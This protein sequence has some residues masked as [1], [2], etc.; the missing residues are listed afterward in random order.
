M[1]F[2]NLLSCKADSFK[3]PATYFACRR[4]C[5]KEKTELFDDPSIFTSLPCLT[6]VVHSS[7]HCTKILQCRP[8]FTLLA[9]V[10]SS[11]LQVTLPVP[12][13]VV[14]SS[15]YLPVHCR[16]FFN[17]LYQ[18]CAVSSNLHVTIPRPCNV[19]QL[20]R[21]RNMPAKYRPLHQYVSV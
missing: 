1:K 17:L 4:C 14:Q 15:R 11:S 16:P 18:Y 21:H 13:I 2:G 20:S 7:R 19:V 3:I 10:L 6:S 8:V 5:C 9:R 12:F